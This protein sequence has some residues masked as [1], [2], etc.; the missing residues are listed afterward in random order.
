VCESNEALEYN[1]KDFSILAGLRKEGYFSGLQLFHPSPAMSSI[2][3]RKKLFDQLVAA[4]GI[5]E[6]VVTQ[7]GDDILYM[8]AAIPWKLVYPSHEVY[9]GGNPLGF[10][11]CGF[12]GIDE[13]LFAGERL[14]Q[15]FAKK[16]MGVSFV[17]KL[18]GEGYNTL[19]RELSGFW[20]PWEIEV[21][22]TLSP[23][24]ISILKGG[25]VSSDSPSRVPAFI[26]YCHRDWT[27][28]GS[29]AIDNGQRYLEIATDG[30]TLELLKDRV[31]FL[32]DIHFNPVV[33]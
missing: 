19:F 14:I 31:A 18:T 6:K 26:W 17:A 11:A 4:M 30:G 22:G 33:P 27:A 29:V 2:A 25:K 3:C 21:V 7:I 10:F 15:G 9:G 23:E 1:K 20:H 32:K 16:I 8:R 28:Y 13:A 24:A 12:A 5:A